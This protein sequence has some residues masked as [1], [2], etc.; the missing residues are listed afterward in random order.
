M[1]VC[2]CFGRK[3]RRYLERVRGVVLPNSFILPWSLVVQSVS[4]LGSHLTMSNLL[5]PESA[6]VPAGL[7]ATLR[8]APGLISWD[9]CSL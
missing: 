9:A 4:S 6:T 5:M 2:V 3:P 1:L 7:T 8:H